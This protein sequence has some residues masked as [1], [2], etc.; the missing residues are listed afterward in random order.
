MAKEKTWLKV[1]LPGTDV[2]L[3]DEETVIGTVTEVVIDPNLT[4]RYQ[5][6]WWDRRA[7]H[8]AYFVGSDLTRVPGVTQKVRVQADER[9][10][11]KVHDQLLAALQLTT[12]L[13]EAAGFCVGEWTAEH[14][15]L[16]RQYAEQARE[17][18]ASAEEA[19]GE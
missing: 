15:A 16:A 13:V 14:V 7:L 4:V 17:A 12:T 18:I 6:C 2:Y 3:D 9:E 8:R 19:S 11:S 10:A 1:F 5:V